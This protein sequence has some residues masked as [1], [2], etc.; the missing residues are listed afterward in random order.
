MKHVIA[1]IA[2]AILT[3]SCGALV[4]GA[5]GATMEK[6]HMERMESEVALPE[7]TKYGAPHFTETIKDQEGNQV[8]I[9]QYYVFPKSPSISVYSRGKTQVSCSN[10]PPAGQAYREYHVVDGHVIYIKTVG[11]DNSTSGMKI[12]EYTIYG[13]IVHLG[14]SWGLMLIQG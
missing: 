8:E 13:T 5:Y 2:L 14:A 6:T 4:G 10:V 1:V 3:Q 9:F 11:I 7:E 12:V